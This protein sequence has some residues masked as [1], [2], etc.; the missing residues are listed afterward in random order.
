MSLTTKQIIETTERFAVRNYERYPV[1]LASGHGAWIIDI[2]GKDYLDMAAGYGAN[3]WGHNHPRITRV[4]QEQAGKLN[5]V[6]GNYYNEDHAKLLEVLCGLCGK[7]KV[8][9][10]CEG[11]VSVEA[12]IKIS[13]K[14]GY[15]KKGIEENSAEILSTDKNFHGRSLGAIAMSPVEQYRFGFG[16]LPPGFYKQVVFGNPDSLEQ[17]ITKNTVA[18]FVEIIAGEGGI[19]VSPDVYFKEVEK[20]CRKNNV[21]LVV[22]EI[23]TG[24][25]RTGYDFAYQHE[26]IEPDIIIIGKSLGGGIVPLS[27]VLT[28]DCIM[29]VISPGDHGSTFGGYPFGCAI[30]LESLAVLKE[31]KLSQRSREMGDYLMD[32]L[33]SIKSRYIKEIRGRGLFIGMEFSGI[34]NHRVCEELL[35]EN[36][37]CVTARDNVVRF[38]PPLVISRVDIEWAVKRIEKILCRKKL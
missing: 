10:S 11:V 1:V 18:F 27:V 28:D 20:I 21:L 31:E 24:L 26:G 19:H 4:A 38:T 6:S 15:L 37:L 34:N 7:D 29:R 2:D 3:N 36:L 9:F 32:G 23:Q 35:K 30:G 25:G 8:L 33:R 14:W 12:A 22:D 16:P 17:A 5:V 13:R